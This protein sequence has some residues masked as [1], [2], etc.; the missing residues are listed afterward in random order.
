MPWIHGHCINTGAGN[1]ASAGINTG[2]DFSMVVI[3]VVHVWSLQMP[4]RRKIIISA[5]FAS[6]LL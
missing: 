4:I 1:V 6:G 3:P 2:F 5:V